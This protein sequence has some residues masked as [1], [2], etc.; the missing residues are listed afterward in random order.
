MSSAEFLTEHAFYRRSIHD[1]KLAD[2]TSEMLRFP[3]ERLSNGWKSIKHS[4]YLIYDLRHFYKR[5]NFSDFPN[6]TN[7]SR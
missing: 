2:D 3:S 7:L 1:A 4:W 6:N 5:D